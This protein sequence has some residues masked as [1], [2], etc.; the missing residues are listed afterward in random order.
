M[1][2]RL[3]VRGAECNQ[4]N[5]LVLAFPTSAPTDVQRYDNR[6]ASWAEPSTRAKS[7]PRTWAPGWSA[8]RLLTWQ[9]NQILTPD[10]RSAWVPTQ[11]PPEPQ[12]AQPTL[13][14]RTYCCELRGGVVR[15]EVLDEFARG[16]EAT[17]N[18]I[19]GER[20]EEVHRYR[21]YQRNPTTAVEAPWH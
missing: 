3:E 5:L 18:A 9:S 6:Q 21:A 10:R 7:A 4:V 15:A 12:A 8:S 17:F 13:K 1:L 14:A 16:H 2:K 11:T 19:S 20:G